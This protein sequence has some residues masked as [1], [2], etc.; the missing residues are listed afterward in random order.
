MRQ[1][2]VATR[3]PG[4][5][6]ELEHLLRGT[7]GTV[8]PISSFP[9][10]AEVEE[11]GTTFTENAVKKA[12]YAA[13]VTGLPAL[14][15]DSGLV[16]DALHG[17]PG[18]HS[19]RFAGEE[20]G[21]AANNLKLLEELAEV[22]STHRTAAFVCVLALCT[23]DG[24][25]RTFDGSLPGMI[26]HAPRGEGGFG[27]DPLFLVPRYGESLAQLSMEIKNQISHRGKA[28]AQ[29]KRYLEESGIIPL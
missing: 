14:A 10:T 25:C 17:R 26:L 24:I 22:P 9:G 11:D 13:L 29:L 12:R 3:N 1:L 8:L 2:V 18:V 23:P 4:K 6:R 20:A 19:A 28:L 15:D 5:I 7:V 21:D 16:V 27:Y